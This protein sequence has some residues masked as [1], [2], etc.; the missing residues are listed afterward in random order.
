MRLDIRTLAIICNLVL[1]GSTLTMF[2]FWRTYKD[3]PGTGYWLLS[4]AFA[5]VGFLLIALRSLVADS[6]SILAANL[7]LTVSFLFLLAG[8]NNLVKRKN[9]ISLFSTI[10]LIIAA[11]LVYFTYIYPSVSSR[12]VI[13]SL[14]YVV[15]SVICIFNLKRSSLGPRRNAGITLA[16]MFLFLS[17]FM[18]MRLIVTLLSPGI[19]NL[20]DFMES[21]NFQA[22]AF[23]VT[24]FFYS[25]LTF[26]FIWINYSSLDTQ[27]LTLLSAIEQATTSIII[28]DSFGNIEYVNPAF[29]LK[30]GYSSKESIGRNSRFLKNSENEQ[31]LFRVMWET[32]NSGRPWNGEFHNRK[33]NGELYWDS[34]SIAPV[35]DK[36]GN[37]THFVSVN[38]DITESKKLQEQLNRLANHDALTGL[39]SRRLVMD[40]LES[41][42]ELAERNKQLMAVLFADL[43]R[44]KEVND[45]LGHDAGDVILQNVARLLSASLR[46]ADTVARLGGDEFLIVLPQIGDRDGASFVAQGMIDA[47]ASADNVENIGLSVGIALYPEHGLTAKD[48][49]RVADNSMYSV[50]KR[51][52]NSWSF[53]D[54]SEGKDQS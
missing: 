14:M 28:T 12:I 11:G 6:L 17:A 36:K 38:E 27:R 45:K 29:S 1:L 40:R 51:G 2:A 52:R 33:K 31:E 48:L 32:I 53:G 25:G 13:M 49:I 24:L 44:F 10:L 7:S 3:R 21:G 22:S 19:E 43:D 46:K 37:I 34:A 16:S 23:I 39:P 5:F 18:A 9:T 30:T 50:K 42:L 8:I 54:L 4:F 41:A 26:T 47:I 15:L 35:N 20:N